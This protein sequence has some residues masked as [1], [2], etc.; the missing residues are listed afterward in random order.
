MSAPVPHA[1]RRVARRVLALAVGLA[2]GLLLLELAL[3]ALPVGPR[4]FEFLNPELDMPQVFRA[5]PELFWRLDPDTDAVRAHP[6]GVRGRWPDL[7]KRPGDLRVA[8]VG[9]SCTYGWGVRYEETWGAR[10]EGLLRERLPG[11]DV[12]C[13][14]L[15]C[16]GYSTHQSRVLLERLAPEL[17]PDWTVVYAGA[18]N[19][20]VPALVQPDHELAE[21]WRTL[22]LARRVVAGPPDR[23]ALARDHERGIHPRGERV[24][25]PR[26]RENLE[27]IVARARVTGRAVLVVPP[28]PEGTPAPP[29]AP[30]AESYRAAV[31]D[32][33]R[34]TGCA[35]VDGQQV[36]DDFLAG[37]PPEWRREED[38]RSVLFLD[39][40]HPSELG[41]RVLARAVLEAIAPERAPAPSARALPDLEALSIEP[42][43]VAWEG[44]VAV[45][46]R[47]RGL[48]RS[49]P[50][51]AAW[52]GDAWMEEVRARADGELLLA[53]RRPLRPGT[54]RLAL[55]TP[56]GTVRTELS[57]RVRGPLL[58][59]EVEPG[60]D[61]GPARVVARLHGRPGD[62]AG[63]WASVERLP[64]PEPTSAGDF[65][66]ATTPGRPP[67]RPDLPFQFYRARPRQ[68]GPVGD[69][70][71]FEVSYPLEGDDVPEVLLLQGG[72]LRERCGALSDP[73]EVRLPRR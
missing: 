48:E 27:A 26:F 31:R 43:E 3:R 53:T 4:S 25:L 70:G 22:A 66:L 36:F 19:D 46:V 42:A 32:V 73:V 14:L 18:W 55:A 65:W 17:A 6:R 56:D 38:G 39:F 57:V 50:V 59:A 58:E 8:C 10:L 20:W 40:V 72:L 13:A 54:A 62:I 44:P 47:T 11:R 52:L 41:H 1:A 33:A 5:D 34:A 64:R 63:I 12:A 23:D 51:L 28:L 61:A 21:S 71:T 24:P 16:T 15:A 35:L 37:V 49:G 9:D 29:L 7:P 60:G 67:E 69:G 68:L 45:R 30:L 2:A